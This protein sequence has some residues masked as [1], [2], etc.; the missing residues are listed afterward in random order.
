MIR[1]PG[2]RGTLVWYARWGLP[3]FFALALSASLAYAMNA[4]VAGGAAAPEA[5]PSIAVAPY[6][7]GPLVPESHDR[8]VVINQFEGS[9]TSD[10]CDVSG[11]RLLYVGLNSWVRAEPNVASCPNG[12]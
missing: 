12:G 3:W 5:Q 7:A 8:S 4:S 6:S 9:E 1:S 11:G 10:G 2:V